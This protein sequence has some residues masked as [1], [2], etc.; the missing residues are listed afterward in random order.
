MSAKIYIERPL[1]G[2][3]A[4]AILSLP[5]K[6]ARRKAADI[7]Y[8]MLRLH[9]SREIPL[10][11]PL[12][13]SWIHF[14]ENIGVHYGNALHP[15]IEAGI[16]ER[17]EC[18]MWHRDSVVDR[19]GARDKKGQCNR[20]RFAPTYVFSEPELVEV[21]AQANK[22]FDMQ[23]DVVRKTVAILARLKVNIHGGEKGVLAYVRRHVTRDFV[24]SLLK[25]GNEIAPGAYKVEGLKFLQ[26]I[27]KIKQAATSTGKE[28]ILYRQRI[29]IAD[30]GQ[31]I[32]ERLCLLSCAYTDALCKLKGARQR[33]NLYCAR[34][35][36][37]NRLDTNIT[38]LRA[39]EP[40]NL[41]KTITLDGEPLVSIDLKNSQ[42][43][44]LAHAMERINNYVST[45]CNEND[46]NILENIA[47]RAAAKLELSLLSQE[48]RFNQRIIE[49]LTVENKIPDIYATQ[50]RR[51][52]GE[53]EGATD[54]NSK[55]L[56]AFCKLTKSGVFYEELAQLLSDE[57]GHKWHRGDAKQTCFLTL[58]S[59]WRYN[60]DE[61]KL[62]ARHFPGLVQW[63]DQFKKSHQS[64]YKAQG[65]EDW[66]E[67]GNAAL[68]VFLQRIEAGIFID[69]IL[70]DL[71]RS[72]YNVLS[73]HDSIMCK[74]SDL[75]EVHR[76]ITKHLNEVLGIGQYVL[77]IE[78]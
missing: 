27:E 74:P 66:R 9:I 55:S 28:A 60:P 25:V 35:E 58:F 11:E 46:D 62:L 23:S 30:V 49:L 31:F 14:R 33:P 17:Q 40:L 1:P 72:G 4:D 64:A 61:K 52:K 24:R 20:Y 57:T 47:M 77:A 2:K 34:N 29:Y 6:A 36:T 50:F 7:A 18:A 10:N 13:I 21:T 44:L 68:A 70:A 67:A 38:N 63:T 69:R 8:Y 19:T 65:R 16:I 37:N 15:L 54:C 56:E 39:K 78:Q 22:R 12:E 5:N 32:T 51:N 48:D 43:T 3:I 73:K 45:F 26:D 41:L 75:S 71:L 42:F 59:S 76:I 53:K